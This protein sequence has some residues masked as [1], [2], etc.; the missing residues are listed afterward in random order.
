MRLSESEK[1]IY[2][3]Q[4]KVSTQ[5]IQEL[6]QD[7]TPKGTKEFYRHVAIIQDIKQRFEIAESSEKNVQ[8]INQVL[9]KLYE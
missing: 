7:V 6:Q 9:S 3:D 2:V 1:E 4:I 8:E 5:K